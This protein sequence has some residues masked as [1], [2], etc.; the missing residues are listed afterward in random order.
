[1]NMATKENEVPGNS[2]IQEV[3]LELIT[4]DSVDWHATTFSKTV[5][6]F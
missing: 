1:M 5:I 2:K 4:E 3:E 6:P